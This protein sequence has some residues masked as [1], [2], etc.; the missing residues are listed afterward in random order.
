MKVEEVHF[1]HD[2]TG[3]S[4]DA[5][6]LRVNAGGTP[7]TAPEWVRGAAA[8]P[9]AYAAGALGSNITIKARFSGGPPNTTLKLRAVDSFVPPAQG[10]CLGI[11][12]AIVAAILR[13]LFG[14]VLGDAKE[15]AVSFDGAGNSGLVTFSLVNHKLK[16]AGVGVRTTEWKWQYRKQGGWHSFDTTRHRTYL[17]V[18]V[19][20]GPWTQ[21][22]SGNDTQVPWTDALDKACRWAH[23]AKTPD[24]AAERI[25]R[26]IN[27]R[28]NQSYT[29]ATMFGFYD[30]FLTSYMNALDAG[31][32]FQLNCTDCANAVVTFS[33][34][35]G[36][37]LW[38]G[39]FFNMV[40]RR[41]LTLNGDPVVDADWVSWT[42]GYHEIGWLNAVGADQDIYDGCLQVDMDDDD[43][44]LVHVA[45]LPVKMRFGSTGSEHYRYRLIQSGAGTLENIPRRRTVV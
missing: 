1:N 41:F 11:L 43:A 13:A 19:P 8:K 15:V 21:S 35:L 44:D 42:W 18:D 40:T 23:G 20:A 30:Y 27:S 37:D 25:T 17:V 5:L 9:A 26:A 12:L 33:N 2:P 38:E 34:L 36:C 32:S 45:R 16:T 29:P 31:A 10:G 24:Q 14:N 7:I 4:A 22:A 6:N 39:R 28:P 3:A